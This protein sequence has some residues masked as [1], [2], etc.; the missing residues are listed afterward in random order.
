MAN[1]KKAAKKATAPKEKK[2]E[3]PT[4]VAR[5]DLLTIQLAVKTVEV[6]VLREELAKLR[7]SQGET[8]VE[9]ARQQLSE[10][11]SQANEKY[12]LTPGEDS[13]DLNTGTIKRG[14]QE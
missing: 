5:E 11:G 1:K 14:T 13:Y 10:L 7:A 9:Q 2:T 8:V 3:L 6:A 4:E 12:G